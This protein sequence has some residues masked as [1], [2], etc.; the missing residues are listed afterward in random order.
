M[1]DTH[2]F[3]PCPASSAAMPKA[4]GTVKPM[5]PRY[6]NGGR[7]GRQ[8]GVLRAGG[9]AA[10]VRRRIR[11]AGKWPGRAVDQGQVEHLDREKHAE[12]VRERRWLVTPEPQRDGGDIPGQ[13][14][15]PEQQ[16]AVI[17]RPQGQR[18]EEGGGL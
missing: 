5:N 11:E 7:G 6:R 9:G 12:G 18:L 8:G 3:E 13:D 2:W 17:S 14:E 1:T 10:A 15:V 4:K 16:R